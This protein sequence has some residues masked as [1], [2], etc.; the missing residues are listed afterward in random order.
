MMTI[1]EAISDLLYV[2]DTLVVP[3]LGAFVKKPVSAKV[4]PVANYF[5]M[6]SSLVE[7]DANVR[8][9]NDLIVN[10]VSERSD[11]SKDEARRLLAMF[12]S[13]CFNSLK[14]DKKVVLSNI[15]TL[16]NDGSGNLVF[17]QNKTVNY[18]ADAFG[19]SDFSPKPVLRTKTKDEIKAEIME[20]QKYK[21][22][23]VTVD[24]K[25]VHEK[26]KESTKED[27]EDDK[28][29][30]A[31]RRL[32]ILWGFLLVAIGYGLHYFHI[33][34]FDQWKQPKRSTAPL[35]PFTLPSYSVD[36]E[37][38]TGPVKTETSPAE[39]VPETEIRIV[40][41]CF[42][43]KEDALRLVNSLKSKGYENAFY[44][45]RNKKWYVSFGHYS[46]EEEAI[47]TLREIRA[48]TEYKAWI[49]K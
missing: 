11:I 12:V 22:T 15:G 36:W 45:F 34:D 19:L 42:G 30:H 9:D 32:W 6:P 8:E 44:E 2:R 17:E 47:A 31:R 10:Y 23:P 37:A 3:G 33:I 35:P 14:S 28:Q 21:N 26:D 40:A 49:L 43:Q 48:N 46:S 20:Q 16:Y 18:N 38:L 24:E 25:A 39:I 27:D 1:A 7:F 41:G 4:N 13:D 5:T 29:G